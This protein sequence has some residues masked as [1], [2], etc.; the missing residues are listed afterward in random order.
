MQPHLQVSDTSAPAT[1]R[2]DNGNSAHKVT[3]YFGN[4]GPSPDKTDLMSAIGAYVHRAANS[5]KNLD[6]YP[7]IFSDKYGMETFNKLRDQFLAYSPAERPMLTG[8]A[9]HD[10]GIYFA[11][12]LR[13]VRAVMAGEFEFS[14]NQKIYIVGHGSASSDKIRVDD[15]ILTMKDVSQE[16]EKIGVP[17]NIRDVRLTSCY[18]A[19][20]RKISTLKGEN[21]S[22]FCEKFEENGCVRKAPAK[23]LLDEMGKAEF[24]EVTITGYHGA[25]VYWDG[26]EFPKSSLRNANSPSSASYNPEDMVK[27]STVSVKFDH[28]TS[29]DGF[30]KLKGRE[31]EFP[32]K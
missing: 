23:H 32:L 1:R 11:Y 7:L 4:G 2:F 12:A 25:G 22:D 29:V 14:P 5:N 30:V 20:S 21:L 16:L 3:L 15:K 18:S 10:V 9:N 17:K 8:R 28:G 31:Y 6:N 27:R 13:N 19:D 26:K 24:D